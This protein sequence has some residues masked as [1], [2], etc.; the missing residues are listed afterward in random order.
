VIVSKQLVDL[1]GFKWECVSPGMYDDTYR[2][3]ECG[4]LFTNCADDVDK[5]NGA[6]AQHT[7]TV[8]LMASAPVP[9]EEPTPASKA[10]DAFAAKYDQMSDEWQ[11]MEL[12]SI[13]A[14]G[15]EAG[16][17]LRQLPPVIGDVLVAIGTPV[18]VAGHAPGHWLSC[19]IVAPYD[20]EHLDKDQY[21]LYYDEGEFGLCSRF[22]RYIENI[23]LT[24]PNFE[25]AGSPK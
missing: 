3:V 16:A 11:D 4:Y 23:R 18:W 13:F 17:N 9:P 19:T 1:F 2:C 21:M 25:Q 8:G 7:C 6:R 5:V 12:S 15:F 22:K 20:S 14:A 24:D 10:F